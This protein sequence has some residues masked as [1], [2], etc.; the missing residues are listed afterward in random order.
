MYF[1]LIRPQ[2]K[3]QQA[4]AKMQNA[5]KKNDQVVTIGGLH[6]TIV[7]V[8]ETVVTLRLD[9]NVRVDVDKSAIAR[10]VKEG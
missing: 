1:L 4:L 6:G 5:L 8:K 9:D 3:Q 2:Q 10:L 7:N